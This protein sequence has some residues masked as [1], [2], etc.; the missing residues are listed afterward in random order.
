MNKISIKSKDP[1]ITLTPNNAELTLN[2]EELNG[3][4][5]IEFSK[6]DTKSK[7]LSVKIELLVRELDLEGFEEST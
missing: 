2:G 3:V 5:S 7:F 4:L 6:F 1:G